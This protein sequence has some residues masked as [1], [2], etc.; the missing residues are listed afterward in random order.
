MEARIRLASG[1]DADQTFLL[2][3]SARISLQPPSWRR[4]RLSRSP[5]RRPCQVGDVHDSGRPFRV[6]PPPAPGADGRQ[7]WSPCSVVSLQEV[8][9]VLIATGGQAPLRADRVDDPFHR[10]FCRRRCSGDVGGKRLDQILRLLRRAQP[11]ERHPAGQLRG[12]VPFEDADQQRREP[13]HVKHEAHRPG[14]LVPTARRRS[15]RL[16]G[17]GDTRARLRLPEDRR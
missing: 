2:H 4:R 13:P 1:S 6:P 14:R 12:R 7:N 16:A 10:S 3:L 8:E 5:R 15:P 11:G 9:D 17:E